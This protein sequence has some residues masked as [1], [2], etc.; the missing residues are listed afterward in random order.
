MLLAGNGWPDTKWK[1]ECEALTDQDW[2]T[3]TE[4]VSHY[5]NFSA[6][7]G[8][9]RGGTKL[10]LNLAAYIQSS[11]DY[12]H[13]IVDDVYTTG[14]SMRACRDRLRNEGVLRDPYYGV[15]LFARGIVKEK[16]IR[17][18]FQMW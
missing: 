17:P 8:V 18:I 10:A 12:G 6:V 2:L 1:I 14:G 16:W 3:V 4:W 9:P 5:Y 7:C 15:V 11:E 13:L